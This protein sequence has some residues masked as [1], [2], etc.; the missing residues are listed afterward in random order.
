MQIDF[1]ELDDVESFLSVEEGSYLCRVA[2][3]REGTTRE[4]SPRWSFRLEVVEGKRRVGHREKVPRI[5]ATP[6]K[7]GRFN[8]PG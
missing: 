3:V 5:E 8:C 6:S 4:G 7:R 1:S 2:E